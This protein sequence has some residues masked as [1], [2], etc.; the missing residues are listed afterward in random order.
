MTVMLSD[1]CAHAM[2]LRTVVSVHMSISWQSSV[3]TACALTGGGMTPKYAE[4]VRLPVDH[5]RRS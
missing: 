2:A 1:S 4:E 3:H 5:Q